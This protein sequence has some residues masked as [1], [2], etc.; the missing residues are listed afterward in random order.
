MKIFVVPLLFALMFCI[1]CPSGGPAVHPGSVSNVDSWAY[2]IL[3]VEQDAINQARTDFKAGNLP[4]S[5]KEPLN[6]AIA[7]YNVALAAWQ[8]YH[9]GL[10]TDA[11]ALQNSVNALVGAFGEVQKL[12][13]KKPASL[14]SLLKWN[15]NPEPIDARLLTT[16]EVLA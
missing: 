4:A 10:T 16:A 14:G 13:G 12:I 2:D 5:A 1:G 3:T 6:T 15:P 9:A 7:Q 11:T 8:S